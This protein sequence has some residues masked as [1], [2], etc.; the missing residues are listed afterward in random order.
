MHLDSQRSDGWE[1]RR[2]NLLCVHTASCLAMK[3]VWVTFTFWLLW[4]VLFLE[5]G[6]HIHCCPC[7]YIRFFLYMSLE[8][9]FVVLW[10]CFSAGELLT[11]YLPLSDSPN[12]PFYFGLRESLRCI[13]ACEAAIEP[14]PS[15]CLQLVSTKVHI[16]V[17]WNHLIIWISK[18]CVGTLAF[19]LMWPVT[20]TGFISLV[21]FLH[22]NHEKVRVPSRLQRVRTQWSPEPRNQHGCQTA[23]I[24]SWTETQKLIFPETSNGKVS[25]RHIYILALA[26]RPEW[27]VNARAIKQNFMLYI[28]HSLLRRCDREVE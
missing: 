10:F 1:R 20:F 13:Q 2:A 27:W 16:L 11:S 5:W 22:P 3:G 4:T 28:I 14:F 18:V 26:T 23:T 12:W 6:V 21:L 9:A 7:P 24:D 17:I 19:P 8:M 15:P 25:R